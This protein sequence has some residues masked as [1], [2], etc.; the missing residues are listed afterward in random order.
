MITSTSR[1]PRIHVDRIGFGLP[2]WIRNQIPFKVP[3][4]LFKFGIHKDGFFNYGKSNSTNVTLYHKVRTWFSTVQNDHG[5]KKRRREV[6]VNSIVLNVPLCSSTFLFVPQRSFTFLNVPFCS[7][8]FLFVPQ[9]F[10]LFLNVPFRSSTFLFVVTDVNRTLEHLRKLQ[11]IWP[12]LYFHPQKETGDDIQGP[13]KLIGLH[14]VWPWSK[15]LM[16]TLS[17]SVFCDA[18]FELTVY[19]LLQSGVHINPGWKQSITGPQWGIS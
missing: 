12:D 19:H 17:P 1:N 9:R 5:P 18:T 14:I 15:E 11:K 10:F 4:T 8:T 3:V 16:K 7:S 2:K 13:V 6:K